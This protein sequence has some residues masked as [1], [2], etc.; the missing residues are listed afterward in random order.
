M[1]SLIF[2]AS[3]SPSSSLEESAKAEDEEE[4]EEGPPLVMER[5]EP[6]ASPRVILGTQRRTTPSVESGTCQMQMLGSIRAL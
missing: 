2:H 1:R 6:D 3:F 5:F 4:E